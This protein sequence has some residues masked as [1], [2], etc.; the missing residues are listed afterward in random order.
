[1]RKKPI[2]KSI[3]TIIL[4]YLF[5]FSLGAAKETGEITV[6]WIY[7]E[8]CKKITDLP[9]FLW[10][11]DNSLLLYDTRKPEEERIF[12]KFNPKNGQSIPLVDT[13][14]ALANLKSLTGSNDAPKNLTWPLSFDRE[15]E[16]AVYI[17]NG[18]IYLLS[19]KQSN[20]QRLTKTKDE[21]RAVTFSPDG[22][23]LA[24]VRSNDLY[25]YEL[26]KRAEKRI[27]RD[28]SETI[29]NGAPSYVYWEDI[30]GRQDIAYSWSEDSQAIAFLQSDE[31]NL[32]LIPYIDYR[33][34][35]PKVI[36][37]RYAK[38]GHEN[39]KVRIGIVE[40]SQPE[41][42]WVD[43]SNASFGYIARVKWLPDS[44][45]LSV[46]TLNRR[47]DELNLY[48][49]DRWTGKTTHVLKETDE[50]WVNVNDCLTFLKDGQHFI[51]ASERSGYAHL[52]LYTLEGKLVNQV[53]KGN[54]AIREAGYHEPGPGR[55]VV[56]VDEK[57]GWVYFTS[58]KKSSL[59]HHLYRI[60]LDGTG[61]E[62]LTQGDGLH[63][64]DF[65]PNAKYY[66]DRYSNRQI[67]P[68]LSLHKSDGSLLKILAEPR[69]DLL[70]K[71]DIQYP[72]FFT[73]PTSDG[74][75]MPAELLKPK[76]F[77][78]NKKYPLI[79]HVYQGPSQPIVTNAWQSSIYFDQILLKKGYLVARVD[80][81]TSTAISKKLENLL[82][83][84]F[85]Q[86]ESTGELIDLIDAV[87]W[88]KS[89]PY[90][91]PD[92][93]G[94][95]GWSG[96]GSITLLAM[97]RSQEFKAGIAIAARTDWRLYNT[98]W[99]EFVMKRPV[100]NPKGYE[101]SN[102]N[103]NAKDLHGR[104]LIVH[105]TFDNNV[106][107]QNVWIFIDE[108]IKAGKIFEMMFYPRRGHGISDRP[109]RIHLFKTMLDFWCRNL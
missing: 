5:L 70:A 8:E 29:I 19:L 85:R 89:K 1:M 23:K 40:V 42:R 22:K 7:N 30:L 95:W 55:A 3:L 50:A 21:E 87:H 53:T 73:I 34:L 98:T 58:I 104:L 66:I 107:I 57:E 6:D 96:G 109:A 78:P 27:T 90:V 10:L 69:R 48:L 38:A 97:T 35:I 39:P 56:A 83:T 74:F 4:F 51:W 86:M 61:L 17:F 18:D 46:Q 72:E 105:G 11:S 80:N 79:L 59:E 14:K 108:L 54:W 94:I 16:K 68:L 101:E 52:Y 20:F 67:P 31:S 64:I 45:R 81:R 106:H 92:R 84:K 13:K 75:P 88:L 36:M 44:S 60:K 62:R 25:V 93:V 15:G 26:E 43:L 41:I 9:H 12:E 76:D 32:S 102:L 33:P 71:F 37:K 100:D 103:K 28:G 82:W 65:S 77:N 47:Q 63:R 99:T 2:K 91:D 24:F 49:A